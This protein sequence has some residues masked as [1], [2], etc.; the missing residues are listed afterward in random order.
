MKVASVVVATIAVLFGYDIAGAAGAESCPQPSQIG[1]QRVFI[2]DDGS[3]AM[4]TR[5]AVNPDGALAS[6]TVGDHGFTYVANGL[7]IWRDGRAVSC[8]S[9]DAHCRAKFLFGEGL[10]FGAGTQE[11]CVFAMEVET[12]GGIPPTECSKGHIIGNGKGMPKLGEQLATVTDVPV[13]PYVSTTAL[14][15]RVKGAQVYV[16]SAQVPSIVGLKSR[17]GD[18]G[19]VAWVRSREFSEEAFAVVGDI[20]DAFG[21]GSIALHQLLRYGAIRGQKPGPVDLSHRCQQSERDLMKPF[22][23]SP[24]QIKDA[25]VEGKQPRGAA[26]IRAYGGIESVDSIFLGA[27]AFQRNGNAVDEELSAESIK[28]K[29]TAAGYTAA[30]LE[31]MADCLER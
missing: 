4:R 2:F 8:R 30:K 10:S 1:K 27:A 26:D 19:R 20:G 7:D 6:Y 14:T 12:P 23:S 16:D 28:A 17:T 13:T 9:R 21:E 22:V 3:V 15:H 31:R 5:L 29:A 11:F 24:D 25:C 18:L